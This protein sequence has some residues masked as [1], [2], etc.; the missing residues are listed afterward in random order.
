MALTVTEDR[1]FV[2]GDKRWVFATIGFDSSYPTNGEA[3]AASDFD[4]L[5]GLE[6]VIIASS[7]PEGT[8][9]V[10]W[11]RANSKLKV[12]TADGTEQGNGTD[13]G[14]TALQVVVIGY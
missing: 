8:E 11:D 6:E 13:P 7:P 3:L 2:A 1:K 9:V 5:T 10:V 14:I 4:S 12:F